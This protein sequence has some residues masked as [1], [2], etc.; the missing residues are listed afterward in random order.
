MSDLPTIRKQ[1]QATYNKLALKFGKLAK[2][3]IC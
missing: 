3:T 2:V 1:L